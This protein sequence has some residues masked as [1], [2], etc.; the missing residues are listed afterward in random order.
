M[1]LEYSTDGSNWNLVSVINNANLMNPVPGSSSV[2]LINSSASNI[3]IRLIANG[4]TERIMI[5]D[6]SWIHIA[7]SQI[8]N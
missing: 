3:Q 4:E 6:F 7:D 8:R 1:N 5:D 2:V